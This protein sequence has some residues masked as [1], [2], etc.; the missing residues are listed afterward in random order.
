VVL[1][2]EDEEAAPRR[3]D[4]RAQALVGGGVPVP[5][6][7]QHDAAHDD[8]ID[9]AVLQQVHLRAR[10]RSMR[11]LIRLYHMNLTVEQHRF[12]SLEKS[13]FEVLCG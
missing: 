7:L 6:L 11:C 8:V 9:R 5:H 4:E 3:V 10:A 13:R 12:L 2:D 1:V